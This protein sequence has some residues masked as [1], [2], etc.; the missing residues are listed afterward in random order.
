MERQARWNS[1]KDLYP[2]GIGACRRTDRSSSVSRHW[3]RKAISTVSFV[4]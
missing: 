4:A 2:G 3:R 1:P